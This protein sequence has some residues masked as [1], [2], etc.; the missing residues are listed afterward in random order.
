MMLFAP[1]V[2]FYLATPTSGGIALSIFE[3]VVTTAL[4]FALSTMGALVATRRPENGVGWILL[5]AGFAM[6]TGFSA[7]GYVQFSLAEPSGRLPGTEW[8]AWVQQ[9][10]L[11]LG[12]GQALVFLPLVFPNGRLPSRRWRPVGGLTAAALAVIGLTLGFAPGPLEEYPKIENPMG[13]G[14]L[15]GSFWGIANGAGWVLLLGS[16]VLSAASV[17][18]RFRRALGVERQQLKWFAFA[19]ALVAVGVVGV[20]AAYAFSGDPSTDTPGF[21]KTAQLLLFASLIGLPIAVGVAVLRYRLYDVDIIINRALVYGALTVTLALVYLG[22]VATTQ[23]IFRALTGQEKQPQ[24]AI[25]ISTLVIAAL[26]NPLRRRVQG[27]VDRR[28]YRRKYDAVKTLEAFSARLREETDLDVLGDALVGVVQGTV[29][30]KHVSLW[31][32][33]EIV[34][35]EERTD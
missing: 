20:G 18:V 1:A 5:T 15:G 26:F 25:V 17:V 35:K 28:F 14:M 24:L 29:Q 19:A 12:L 23:A 6:G 11:V 32:R 31:L 8:M 13:L 9:W 7:G 33:P 4:V 34:S 3:A 22:G 30:P 10:I 27:V 21:L 2:L 16:V